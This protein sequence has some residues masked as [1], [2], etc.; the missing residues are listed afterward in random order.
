MEIAELCDYY[1]NHYPVPGDNYTIDDVVDDTR[2]LAAELKRRLDEDK[3]FDIDIQ[4]IMD[5]LPP[6]KSGK[7]SVALNK[8]RELTSMPVGPIFSVLE[9]A[10]KLLESS[11][12][13]LQK[14]RR[15]ER[16]AYAIWQW[17][18]A[19]E[20]MEYVPWAVKNDPLI[21]VREAARKGLLS[22]LRVMI[23]IASE[24]EASNAS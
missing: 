18:Q 3:A 2:T 23:K 8:L 12:S 22:E 11:G 1:L 20:R 14:A 7:G 4:R 6:L 19:E 5:S 24:K 13:E 21:P 15:G 9:R 10:A 17:L 16:V